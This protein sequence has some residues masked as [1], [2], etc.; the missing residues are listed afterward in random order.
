MFTDMFNKNSLTKKRG[1]QLSS[2][3]SV[4]VLSKTSKL[5]MAMG[6]FTWLP[7]EWHPFPSW[8]VN[9]VSR[10]RGIVCK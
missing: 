7:E 1:T 8:S 2:L 9:G 10:H 3:F 5:A 4:G 6:K